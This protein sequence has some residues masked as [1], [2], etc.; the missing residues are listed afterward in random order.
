VIDNGGALD[1]LREQVRALHERYVK[2][3]TP[4]PA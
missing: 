4:T 2:M 1:A 3:S